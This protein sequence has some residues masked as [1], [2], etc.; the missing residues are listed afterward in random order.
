MK[1]NYRIK[2]YNLIS[3]EINI[4][5]LL[6]EKGYEIYVNKEEKTLTLIQEDSL[7]DET[8]QKIRNELAQLDER[9][10]LEDQEDS[11]GVYRKVLLLNNLDCPSCAAKV[12]ELVKKKL[13]C[14][15]VI[16]DFATSRMILETID[17]NLFLNIVHEV[18]QV[19]SI[20]DRNI[21]VTD[22]NTNNKDSNINKRDQEIN[23][24]YFIIGIS[25]YGLLVILHYF[26]F[27][28]C[29]K[30]T[31]GYDLENINNNPIYLSL[32]L[33]G[34]SIVSYILLG[35]DV[36][37]AALKNLIHGRVFDEKFLMS[38]AT[39][40]AF[41]IH[42]YFEAIAVMAFYK[43]GELL[44]QKVINQSR[45]SIEALIDI[46]PQFARVIIN[47]KEIEVDP[48]ELVVG[49]IILIKQGER[50]PAD[51]VVIDGEASID[52][53]AI[54]GETKYMVVSKGKDVLSGTINIDG[55]ITV[56][57]K[58]RYSDSMVSKI[59][60]L[61][62]NANTK[63]AKTEKYVTKI[64]KYY[65]PAVC[66]LAFIIILVNIF[67]TNKNFHDSVYP[68][69]VFLVVSCPCAL[70]ISV[71]LAYFGAIGLASKSG[72]LIKGSNYIDEAN[73]VGLVIFDKTGTLTKGKFAVENIVSIND[74]YA[75]E[76]ILEIAAHC[77]TPS[78]H[79]I[80]KSIIK[81]YGTDK[82]KTNNVESIE[83]NKRG[84][85]VRYLE[86]KYY[87]G[88]YQYLTEKH[89]KIKDLNISG[90]VIYL[91]D[92]K[93]VIGY[94]QL[95]DEIREDSK[96]TIEQ[97]KKLNIDVAM[98][99][100]DSELVA[101][102][103]ATELGIDNF[104]Y[105]LTPVEKVKRLRKLKKNYPD[106][107]VIFVGDGVNDTPVLNN[108]DIGIAMGRLG[109]DA[110]I[111]VADIVLMN[112]EIAKLINVF[113]IAKK[114]KEVVLE[115]IIFALTIKIIVLLLAVTIESGLIRM[116]E[117]VFADVGV[118]LI[119]TINSLTVSKGSK[120]ELLKNSIFN[121]KK[122]MKE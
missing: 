74:N 68:A 19:A 85:I 60:N 51:G 1:K 47:E 101:K 46:K 93:N 121:K 45:K 20:V 43:I 33:I 40:I 59:L 50:I 56:K 92:E 64:A 48:S 108:S 13:N 106:K 78:N 80:A 58:K 87:I 32:P 67:F 73:N 6:I 69:M 49:D 81:E 122:K 38:L 113:T 31:I 76:D 79:P 53:S 100:G 103:V 34:L 4:Q 35:Y 41:S 82:I 119:A 2:N 98:L 70:V 77:E 62:E 5:E 12:E 25:I 23:K 3:N 105:G 109:S 8:M 10:D 65:T 104:Y 107:K 89:I 83:L 118:S 44:Q 66:L 71:P 114:T 72:I 94:I 120:Q 9:I 55:V 102:E 112:D 26:V 88:S 17:K 61:V 7:F 15:S 110:A 99:T 29:F 37:L 111:E 75:R 116:W 97:I 27:Y 96:E 91:A 24:I 84:L 36:L 54:T 63:K 117:G 18:Q 39:I 57:V 95:K 28:F 11:Q 30:D 14:A 115:N 52:N 42:S 16:V 22:K 90:F 86:N 21:V